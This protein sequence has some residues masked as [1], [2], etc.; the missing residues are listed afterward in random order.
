MQHITQYNIFWLS[1][2]I[3]FNTIQTFLLLKLPKFSTCD[4][5]DCIG[6][7]HNKYVKRAVLPESHNPTSST[8]RLVLRLFLHKINNAT[9]TGTVKRWWRRGFQN[10][11]T[12]M[13]RTRTATNSS[14][15]RME[16]L[17]G[18]L[19][20]FKDMVDDRCIIG[21]NG[22]I[23]ITYESEMLHLNEVK[24]NKCKKPTKHWTL[25]VRSHYHCSRV[26]QREFV[27]SISCLAGT[28]TRPRR[29]LYAVIKNSHNRFP[30]KLNLFF[31]LNFK[32]IGSLLFRQI[33]KKVNCLFRLI[34]LRLENVQFFY[35]NTLLSILN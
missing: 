24:K 1:S 7:L 35:Y 8:S 32:R 30:P 21:C 34:Q 33:Y 20:K 6:L 17:P 25:S 26:T 12:V 16:S 31:P 9:K 19:V 11:P 28:S 27:F 29:R 23:I 18:V 3:Y 13:R 10:L 4:V 15:V 5:N 14:L 22:K 2:N